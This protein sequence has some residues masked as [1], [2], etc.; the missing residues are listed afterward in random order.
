MV[1]SDAKVFTE[2][3]HGAFARLWSFYVRHRV[4]VNELGIL[5]AVV[6][7]VIYVAYSFDIFVTEGQVSSAEQTIELDEVLLIGVVLTLGLLVFGIRRYMEQK[8]EMRR[9]LEAER[10]ARTLAFQDPLTGLANRR[11]F[12]DALKIAAAQPPAAGS[13]HA[14]L[15]L[16]LNGFKKINDNY[17]HAAGDA[18]L[19]AV[20][21]RLLGA[22]R[23][24]DL[25]ARLGGDEFVVLAPHIL[26]PEGASNIAARI[27][28]SLSQPIAT[29]GVEHNVGSGVGIALLPDDAADPSEALRMADVALYRAKGEH[30][31][32]MR[33]FEEEM[34]L[35]VREREDMERALATAI[36]RDQIQPRFRPSVDLQTGE[37]IGLEVFPCWVTEAGEEIGPERFLALAEETGLVH[38]IGLR[39]LEHA[40]IAAMDWPDTVHLCIDLFPG[41]IKNQQLAQSVLSTLAQYSFSPQRLELE[42][43]ENVIVSDLDA[44]RSAL[45]PL[46]AAGVKVTL[47]NFGTGYSNLYHIREVRFD[48]VKIDRRVMDALG[49]DEADRMIR[50][51]AGLGNGLGLTVSADGISDTQANQ[52]LIQAGIE[53]GQKDSE[54]WSVDDAKGHFMQ[55]PFPR[56]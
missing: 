49:Q 19:I 7:V 26:G 38:T 48:K 40:C 39:L 33:F 41:Q 23:S 5:T 2:E 13:A 29:N 20:S 47:D 8:R 11:Q 53:Q 16:D 42:V 24:Q 25:V 6:A 9:R 12:E 36:Q 27:I 46:Q 22:V 10:Y 43:S 56:H 17:G 35:L 50:A 21:Q 34:D 30:R 45:A 51:L 44:A 1:E 14:V 18:V 15:M 37:V 4:S 55:A 32:A 31:S 3:P 54:V 28:Q 52:L